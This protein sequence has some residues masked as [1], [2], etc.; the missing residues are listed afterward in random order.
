MKVTIKDDTYEKII[1]LLKDIKL[2]QGNMALNSTINR[3][4]DIKRYLLDTQISTL[5][6]L[7]DSLQSD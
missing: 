7:E 3:H 5:Q 4:P 2:T 6:E 1:D